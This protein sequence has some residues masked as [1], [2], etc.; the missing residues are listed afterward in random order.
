IRPHPRRALPTRSPPALARDEGD[1]HAAVRPECQFAHACL[2]SRRARLTLPRAATGASRPRGAADA[3]HL[4]PLLTL[5][6]ISLLSPPAPANDDVANATIVG[7]IPYTDDENTEGATSED[8]DGDCG[9]FGFGHG[10][11]VWYAYTATEDGTLAADTF[12]SDYDTTLS[13]WTGDPDA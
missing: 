1:D 13:V 8:I 9:S 11:S 7:G 6:A 2:Q 5:G 3:R 12:G 4:F 10:H